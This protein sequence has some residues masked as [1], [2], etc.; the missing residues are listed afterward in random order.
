MFRMVAILALALAPLAAL[1]QS[2]GANPPTRFK[3]QVNGVHTYK[4]T[5]QTLVRET[6]LDPQ[7]AMP[8]TT[9]VKTNLTLMKTWTVKAVDA[10]GV[11]TLEM[12]ITAM[13]NEFQKP[14]GK[15]TVIDSA[16]PDDAKQMTGFLN[17]P[18]MTVKVDS[19]GQLVE[20]KDARPGSA[21]RLHAELPFRL[22]LPE[23]GP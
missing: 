19:R 17:V 2:P 1:G 5:Q 6:T 23:T 9:E 13:R 7:T 15:T 8:V 16:N 3:W 11:A 4:V 18:V 10:A 20:V 22:T 21:A 12:T 14:D